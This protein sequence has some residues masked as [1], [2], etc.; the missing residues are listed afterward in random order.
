M[1]DDLKT[2]ALGLVQFLIA[3]VIGV[4]S[5]ELY[6]YS[7]VEPLDTEN[8]IEVMEEV[9]LALSAI[10]FM[11]SAFREVEWRGAMWLI[12]GFF[13]SLL[14]RELDAY[15]DMIQHGAWKYAW[16]AYLV[17][18][19]F[20]LKKAGWSTIVPGLAAYMRSRS[21]L[22]MMPGAAITLSYARL[23]GYK[24]LWMHIMGDYERW[25]AMKTFAEESTEFLGYMLML[26][27]AI[28]W[29]IGRRNVV[30]SG[31]L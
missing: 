3:A 23:Y 9:L 4:A 21:F 29:L 15:F 18:L 6:L 7:A 2:I 10:L 16:M 11:I 30:L 24:G 31:K 8:W 5:F 25:G 20:I 28:F 14:I 26:G 13:V 22:M 27:A 1:S 12:H 17:V 19:F